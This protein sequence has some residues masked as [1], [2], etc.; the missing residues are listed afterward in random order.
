V[1]F[2]DNA[3]FGHKP[4][5]TARWAALSP[6]CALLLPSG[7]LSVDMSNS[8]G[9]GSALLKEGDFGAD[10]I[11]FGANEGVQNHTHEG[12]HILFVVKGEGWVDYEGYAHHL[13][14]GMCYLIPSM[15]QHA[16]RAITE[17]VL[18]AVGNKHRPLE[19]SERMSPV[20]QT[21]R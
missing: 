9:T 12:A 20:N 14:P 6:D 19:S 15:S 1:N 2:P 13:E 7:P 10:L 18:I 21:P 17:L 8:Q 4:F 5:Q 16:I 3:L 11:R